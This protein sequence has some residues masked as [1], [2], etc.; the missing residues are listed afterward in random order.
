MTVR[1][2]TR[3]DT[4]LGLIVVTC[5]VFAIG[6]VI[7]FNKT[8]DDAQMQ[9]RTM[10]RDFLVDVINTQNHASAFQ[11][12]VQQYLKNPSELGLS[13]ARSKLVRL[14]RRADLL[15]SSLM[16][17]QI[18]ASSA[19]AFTEELE[20]F[21]SC[22][23]DLE[24]LLNGPA[25]ELIESSAKVGDL[26]MALEDSM[27]FLF[28]EANALVHQQANHQIN[29]LGSMSTTLS[30][31][32]VIVMIMLVG[33]T[34]TLRTVYQQRSALQKLV[35]KDA[36]T[37]LKNRRG[38]NNIIKSQFARMKRTNGQ[39][40][41]LVLDLDHFK[42]FNDTYGH[43]CG[44]DALVRVAAVLRHTMKRQDDWAFRLGGEEFACL[45]STDTETAAHDMAEHLRKEIMALDILHA[46]SPTADVLTVSIGVAQLP[47]A[48]IHTEDDLFQAAD[49]ALYE[50]KRSGR[51]RV[52]ITQSSAHNLRVV[53]EITG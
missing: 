19:D 28:T 22:I 35:T 16:R 7:S 44:D 27:A 40:S 9:M 3:Q 50:A 14:G 43:A 12:H 18:P 38:F 52:C 30:V 25:S 24:T 8:L 51:N 26:L 33:L 47:D 21:K 53:P 31:L 10:P 48:A 36:L 1:K 11:L 6:L 15:L 37:L 5:A 29:V 39:L 13:I 32:V 17:L 42:Q 4:F 20:Y 34:L 49:T 41:L 45:L 2:P 46:T 23:G